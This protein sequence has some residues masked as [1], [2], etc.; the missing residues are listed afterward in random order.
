[1]ENGESIYSIFL[2]I[3]LYIIGFLFLRIFKSYF[4]TTSIRILTLYTWHS[5][6][7]LIY[8]FYSK[9]NISDSTTYYEDSL[10]DGVNL[11]L[12]T[13]FVT[14][15][16]SIF[17]KNLDFSY[18]NVFMIFNIIG[19]LGLIAFDSSIKFVLRKNKY[20][21]KILLIRNIVFLPSI[22]FWSSALGKDAIS[23]LAVCLALWAAL[24]LGRRWLLM[25]ISILLM[26]LVRPHISVLM[27][28]S[29]VM[30]IL[31]KSNIIS[32]FKKISLVLGLIIGLISV[33]PFVLDYSGLGRDISI[34]VV[35]QYI[36]TRQSFNQ[37]GGGGID[38]SQMSMPAQLF[39]YLFR[40]L[41]FEIQ[42]FAALA[43]SFD[44]ILLLILFIYAGFCFYFRKSNANSNLSNKEFMIIY[45]AITWIILAITTANLGIS[46]RQKWMFL[47][48]LLYVAISFIAVTNPARL[49]R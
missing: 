24:S 44:N 30:V 10:L 4:Q 43:A 8:F 3:L 16:A 46:L 18:N 28:S 48:M 13:D 38:I 17:T 33:I 19:S 40:P 11:A 20:S 14:F 36:E 22:S 21:L 34:Q 26:L 37:E 31:Y 42:G 25:F 15:F 6:F 32:V 41:P 1:M 7:C 39:A 35:N 49:K 45:S 9:K 23:F 29:L 27:I 5:L 12:G 47:P 2:S